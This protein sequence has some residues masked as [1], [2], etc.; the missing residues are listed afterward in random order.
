MNKHTILGISDYGVS[1][2]AES[3]NCPLMHWHEQGHT[4]YHLALGYNG[5][6]SSVDPKLYPWRERL[7]PIQ[8]GND[9]TKFGQLQI[10]QALEISKAD[11]IITSFDVWM[12]NYLMQ[13]STAPFLDEETRKV[14]SH[15]NRKFSH[16]L[17]YPIDG[18]IKGRYL[19]L[20]ME[21]SICGADIP[22]TYSNFS[23]NL[24]KTNFNVDI[25]M[26]PI[27]HDQNIFKPMDK[28]ECRR[29]MHLPEDCFLIG[30]VG[31]NQYRK[32]WGDFF[33]GVI[34]F[35]KKHDNVYILPFTTWGQMIMG[36]CEVKD[37]VYK[38]GLEERI[39]DPSGIVG[40]LSAEG[41]AILYNCFDVLILCTVGE[42]A[43]LPPL[44]ARACGV[45]ALV[46]DNTSNTEFTAHEI[47]RIK[48]RAKYY[49]NFGSNLERYLTDTDDLQEKLEKLYNNPN[50]RMH[51][52]QLGIE[53][54]RQYEK[55][56]VMPAWDAILDSIPVRNEEVVQ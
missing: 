45:P 11:T 44:R 18:A 41:M 13:P 52:G 48:I 20:G 12:C 4:I 21:E 36:G 26:I 32:C 49:D 28:K 54:M 35:A 46:S 29:K 25:P 17:Y 40:R 2:I 33:D 43:G 1:G 56:K 5:I 31:T 34:P 23:Q 3:L 9:H 51:V 24:M 37:F 7:I 53:K 19:P 55:D 10:R 27:S 30:N 38:S 8:P 16:I 6:C 50:L 14:L 15:Q 39:I 42:G 47:E 22:I